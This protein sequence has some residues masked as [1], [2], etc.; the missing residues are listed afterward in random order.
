MAT[1]TKKMTENPVVR[2]IVYL[3]EKQGKKGKELTDYLKISSGSF[4][5][6]KYDGSIVYLKHIEK[7]CEFLGTT[8]NYLFLGSEDEEE[9]LSPSEKEMIRSYRNLD[10]GKKKCIRDTLRYFTESNNSNED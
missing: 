10:A 7:I 3:M 9:K 5:K 2:R 6:W 4:A 1:T 8:P